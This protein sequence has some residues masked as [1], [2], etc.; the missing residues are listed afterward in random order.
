MS[1]D[2]TAVDMFYFK[3]QVLAQPSLLFLEP[4]ASSTI[5]ECVLSL[6]ATQESKE[7]GESPVLEEG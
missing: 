7:C 3:I 5:P 2:L 1:A 6:T 4:A